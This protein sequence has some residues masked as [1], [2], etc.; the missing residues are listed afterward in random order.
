LSKLF[1]LAKFVEIQKRLLKFVKFAEYS[2]YFVKIHKHLYN[3][4]D[5]VRN[6]L[7]YIDCMSAICMNRGVEK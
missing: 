6:L 1:E 4:I 7:K 5:N 2:S 3:I